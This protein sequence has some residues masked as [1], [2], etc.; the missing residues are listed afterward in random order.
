MKLFIANMSAGFLFFI[1]VFSGCLNIN[2]ENR[3]MN[4]TE[5]CFSEANLAIVYSYIKNQISSGNKSF[6]EYG[7]YE[8]HVYENT[9]IALKDKGYTLAK[10][11]K[12]NGIISLSIFKA[13]NDRIV[14][15]T[16]Q[17]F[18]EILAA[19]QGIK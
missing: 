16:S 3:K 7:G 1:I 4:K 5:N 6:Y 17:I 15:K 13:S 12:E 14:K 9:E 18:C 2:A 8:L 10:I 11:N 19:A